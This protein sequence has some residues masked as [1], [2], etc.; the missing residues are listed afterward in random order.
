V[1]I[2]IYIYIYV[3]IY[4]YVC[5][6]PVCMYE[7]RAD[8]LTLENQCAFPWGR[9]LLGY[10]LSSVACSSSYRVAASWAFPCLFSISIDV[11]LVQLLFEN[12]GGEMLKC[13][14]L[15]SLRATISQ[16]P[17]ALVFIYSHPLPQCS[18][19]LRCRRVL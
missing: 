14:V 9:L 16:V 1:Y 2:Y 4:M 3:C 19:I 7:V 13:S 10:Q 8:H 6:K 11:I 18:L 15:M 17:G 12:E 5:I